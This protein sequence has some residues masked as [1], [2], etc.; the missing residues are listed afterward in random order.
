[1]L[2]ALA[3]NYRPRPS[4]DKPVETGVMWSKRR[5]QWVLH[6]R[7]QQVNPR[8]HLQM[9]TD[10]VTDVFIK[11]YHTACDHSHWGRCPK[12]REGGS[13]GS[14]SQSICKE[15][16][17][18]ATTNLHLHRSH[19]H[20]LVQF[21]SP[22]WYPSCCPP[23][24]AGNLDLIPWLA[25]AGRTLCTLRPSLPWIHQVNCLYAAHLRDLK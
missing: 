25:H 4:P 20:C 16:V 18:T 24:G 14:K 6:N 11:K 7:P 15:T 17:N 22:A 23:S 1:M 19:V 12:T 5:K 10:R 2:S 3:W 21:S 9:L 8:T 13:A